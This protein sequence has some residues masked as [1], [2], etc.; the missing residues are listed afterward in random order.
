MPGMLDVDRTETRK[1]KIDRQLNALCD[2]QKEIETG[3]ADP[4]DGQKIQQEIEELLIKLG[5]IRD[6]ERH[7][8]SVIWFDKWLPMLKV[9]TAP[10]A[11]AI[12]NIDTEPEKRLELTT[13]VYIPT[14]DYSKNLTAPYKYRLVAWERN[15]KQ[16]L[17]TPEGNPLAI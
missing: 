11:S 7:Y 15:N 4:R 13:L 5:R 1:R 10:N 14:D 16:H 3:R 9:M 12:A 6:G 17:F 8:A 2:R